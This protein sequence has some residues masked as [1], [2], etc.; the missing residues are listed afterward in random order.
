VIFPINGIRRSVDSE[1]IFQVL[2]DVH[3]FMGKGRNHC[4]QIAGIYHD[5]EAT[6]HILVSE[7]IG[8]LVQGIRFAFQKDVDNYIFVFVLQNGFKKQSSVTNQSVLL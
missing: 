2:L 7:P 3:K 1:T 8:F 6:F 5:I 4:L